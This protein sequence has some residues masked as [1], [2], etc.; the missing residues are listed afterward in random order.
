MSADRFDPAV[1]G[2]CAR[3]A[4]GH[5]YAPKWPYGRPP[6]KPIWLCDDPECI[7]IARNTY[8]MKQDEFDRLESLA[9]VE[10]GH[11]LETYCDAIGKTDFAQFT[12]TE[13]EQAMREVVAEYRFAMKVKLR[14]E[15]PF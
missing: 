2:V 9:T 3:N 7:A 4:T 1:C 15:A 10:A 14:D 6:P 11:K 13:F 12:Q 5:G 8:D